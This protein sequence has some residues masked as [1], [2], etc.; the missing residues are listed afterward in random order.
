MN[1]DILVYGP[2]FCDLIFTDLPGM[3]ELGQELFAGDLTLALG[4]SGIVAVGLHRLGA[5]VGLIAELGQDPMSRLMAQM[6][7]DLGLDRRLIR[8]HP[9]PLPQ[10]TVAL[11]FPQDRAFVTRFERPKEPPDLADLLARHPA[12]HLHICSFLA[13]LE[14]PDACTMAHA[15]GMTVSFDPGW[16]EDALRDPRLRAMLPE[17]DFF[18]PNQ[19]ELCHMA[20]CEDVAEA[21]AQIAGEM[22][23]GMLILK[24]GGEGASA[25]GPDGQ[26]LAHVPAIPVTPIDTTGAGDAFDAGFLYAHVNQ[27]SLEDAMLIGAICGGVATT[28]AGGSLACPTT[29]EVAEWVSKLPSSAEAAAT[30][31]G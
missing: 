12:R 31:Q 24:Q 23:Q 27:F 2:I 22:K 7:D 21:V 9:F 14:N 30:R 19:A 10:V 8:R 20:G 26:R 18:L 29:T 16:D 6:L 15:A 17:L 25:F 11:S 28:K 5:K 3:P 4:G 1:Y 13:A